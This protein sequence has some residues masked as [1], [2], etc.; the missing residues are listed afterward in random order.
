MHTLYQAPMISDAQ[1]VVRHLDQTPMIPDA[2]TVVR[3]LDQTPMIPDAQANQTT[4]DLIKMML[5]EALANQEHGILQHTLFY[6]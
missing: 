5:I 2:Q 3:H 4:I 1:T 6:L